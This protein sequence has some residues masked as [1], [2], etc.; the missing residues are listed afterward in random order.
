MLRRGWRLPV[1]LVLA[2]G[3]LLLEVSPAGAAVVP[4][5]RGAARAG[6][7]SNTELVM[8]GTGPGQ[9]VTGFIANADNPFDPV[10][11]GYPPSNP[12]TGFTPLNEGFAGVIHAHPAGATE[13]V[14]S[15]YCID[16]LTPTFGPSTF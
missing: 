2:L 12:S 4:K 14:L 1:L 16:I 6:V 3:A 7:G 10:A 15:L 8:S 9:A 11:E 5:P 13:P